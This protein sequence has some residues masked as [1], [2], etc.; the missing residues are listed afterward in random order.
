VAV[1]DATGALPPTIAADVS[2]ID[3]SFPA[4][5]SD[6]SIVG[7]FILFGIGL[8]R[9]W[10]YTGGQVNHLLSQYEKV[11]ALWEKVATERQET[12]ELL[13]SNNEAVLKGN[14]A[15]LRAVEELQYQQEIARR[16]SLRDEPRD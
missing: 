11:A 12:I 15:I 13:S 14:E 2:G 6:V 1:P 9:G 3:L 5:V 10:L 7:I 16:H 8:A 4:W